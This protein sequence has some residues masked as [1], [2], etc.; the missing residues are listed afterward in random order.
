MN[1]PHGK[2]RIKQK[3]KNAKNTFFRLMS[4]IRKYYLVHFILVIVFIFAAAYC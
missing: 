3:P 2:Q 1:R 4:Y